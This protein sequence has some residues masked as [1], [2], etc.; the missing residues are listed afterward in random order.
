MVYCR[1]SLFVFF[2]MASFAGSLFC[3]DITGDGADDVPEGSKYHRGEG[4]SLR[5]RTKVV[6]ES[7]EYDVSV[8]PENNEDHDETLKTI[9]SAV[10]D[11]TVDATADA[12]EGKLP[13]E[14]K[15]KFLRKVRSFLRCPTPQEMASIVKKCVKYGVPI[16]VMAVTVG[17]GL[18]YLYGYNFG[19]GYVLSLISSYDATVPV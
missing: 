14:K 8:F 12:L 6:H 10:L 18:E 13:P 11:T 15:E 17:C 1:K 4:G 5:K 19:M 2:V 3:T 7:G 16:G 9:D